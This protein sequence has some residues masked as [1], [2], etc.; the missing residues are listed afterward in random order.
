MIPIESHF[1]KKKIKQT[2]IRLQFIEL[3]QSTNALNENLVLTLHQL[4]LAIHIHICVTYSL[5][6]LVTC[7]MQIEKIVTP[8]LV[9]TFQTFTNNIVDSMIFFCCCCRKA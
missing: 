6:I 4:W 9:H 7:K 5:P 3:N 1:K 8:L 2:L